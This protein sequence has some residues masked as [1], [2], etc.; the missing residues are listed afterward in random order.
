MGAKTCVFFAVLALTVHSSQAALKLVYIESFPKGPTRISEHDF[1]ASLDSQKPY[2]KAT[3][4]DLAGNDGYQLSLQTQRVEGGD[5]KN[6]FLARAADRSAPAL[7]GKSRQ[8]PP[9]RPNYSPTGRRIVPGG[10]IRVRTQCF[11]CLRRA[12]SRQKDYHVLVPEGPRWIPCG[13]NC[14]LPEPSPGTY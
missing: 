5:V 13:W 14:S 4:K 9:C 6:C 11:P 8:W 3:I 2:Y 10:W 1:V 7:S 12:Y